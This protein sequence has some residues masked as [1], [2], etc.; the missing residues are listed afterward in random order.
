MH[1]KGLPPPHC[2]NVSYLQGPVPSPGPP[3]LEVAPKDLP[4]HRLAGPGS[5][6]ASSGPR[7]APDRELLEAK[8]SAR[9]PLPLSRGAPLH[10][11]SGAPHE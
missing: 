3:A 2:L 8:L 11:F 5:T 9:P 4:R 1:R 7:A 10:D 6:G